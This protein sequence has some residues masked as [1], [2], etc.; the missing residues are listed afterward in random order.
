TPS[1]GPVSNGTRALALTRRTVRLGGAT[2]L[3]VRLWPPESDGVQ[4]SSPCIFRTACMAA[5]S[6]ADPVGRFR[7]R[8]THL[9]LH[10]CSSESFCM[11][12]PKWSYPLRHRACRRWL[13]LGKRVSAAR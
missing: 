1:P 10:L 6:E 7:C 12:S 8:S 9:A 11:A 13:T 5:A 2:Y 3:Q 4:L